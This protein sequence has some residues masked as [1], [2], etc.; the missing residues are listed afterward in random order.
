[1]PPNALPYLPQLLFHRPPQLRRQLVNLRLDLP[2][3]CRISG[4]C[5]FVRLLGESRQLVVGGVWT[6]KVTKEPETHENL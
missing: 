2:H 5:G 6:T 4:C 1:M 3:P